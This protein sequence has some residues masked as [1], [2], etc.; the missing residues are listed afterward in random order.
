MDF[1]RNPIKSSDHHCRF[2]RICGEGGTQ[3][4]GY[5]IEI[6]INFEHIETAGDIAA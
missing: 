1:H 4:K 3:L 2:C 5:H 6:A